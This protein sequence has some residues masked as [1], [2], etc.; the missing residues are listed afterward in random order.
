M[1]YS[2]VVCNRLGSHTCSPDI[3]RTY[4]DLDIGGLGNYQSECACS[5]LAKVECRL[6]ACRVTKVRTLII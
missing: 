4:E 1:I 2:S 3:G 5:S 6:G